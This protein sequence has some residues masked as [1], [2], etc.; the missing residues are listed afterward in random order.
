MNDEPYRGIVDTADRYECD[1]IAMASHGRHGFRSLLGS[2]TQR[3]LLHS[4]VPV[5][6]LT[7][8]IPRSLHPAAGSQIQEAP[9]DQATPL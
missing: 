6:V 3:V 4:H 8:N 5:L 9:K 7:R 1:L 2:T